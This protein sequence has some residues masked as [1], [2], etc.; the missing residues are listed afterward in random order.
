MVTGGI[1]SRGCLLHGEGHSQLSKSCLVHTELHSVMHR[2]SISLVSDGLQTRAPACDMTSLPGYRVVHEFHAAA[3]LQQVVNHKQEYY[4]PN[5][6]CTPPC[7]GSQ[8]LKCSPTRTLCRRSCKKAA[9]QDTT[10]HGSPK[11]RSLLIRMWWSI[12]SKALR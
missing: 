10:E 9:T 4:G 2:P 7:I 12:R 1:S 5:T 8:S 11:W 6:C 3:S